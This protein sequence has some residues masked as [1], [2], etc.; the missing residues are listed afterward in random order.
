[1]TD[2]NRLLA[3]NASSNSLILDFIS[4]FSF[5][6]L[7]N[8]AHGTGSLFLAGPRFL[9]FDDAPAEAAFAAN[10]AAFLAAFFFFC[11]FGSLL[12]SRR[13]RLASW[14]RTKVTVNLVLPL[15]S[16]VSTFEILACVYGDFYVGVP[17]GKDREGRGEKEKDNMVSPRDDK[18][19]KQ[20]GD[21]RGDQSSRE[22]L[23]AAVFSETS[24]NYSEALK[25]NK[26]AR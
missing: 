5:F 22:A 23:F 26:E 13:S 11:T 8:L 2:C 16:L 19:S 6:I 10:F 3:A 9:F 7:A 4:A 20:K 24:R 15:L 25:G 14:A 12:W 1:M 21:K 18:E 17:L